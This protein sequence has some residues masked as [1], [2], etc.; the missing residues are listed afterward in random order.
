M[1]KSR[2]KRVQT[3]FHWGAYEV[4]VEDSGGRSSFITGVLVNSAGIIASGTIE[5]TTLEQFDQMMDVAR[6]L[7]EIMDARLVDRMREAGF[8]DDSGLVPKRLHQPP[9]F[10]VRVLVA[11]QVQQ[12][13]R[14]LQ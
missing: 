6:R 5:S 12:D 8:G 14:P 13:L 2:T 11:M 3:S 9:P 10:E 1:N 7:F 4:E